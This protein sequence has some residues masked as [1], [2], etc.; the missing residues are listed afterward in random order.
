MNYIYALINLKYYNNNRSHVL[1]I[2][3]QTSVSV[4]DNEY[5]IRNHNW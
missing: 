5:M 2:D 1:I 3:H 4:I